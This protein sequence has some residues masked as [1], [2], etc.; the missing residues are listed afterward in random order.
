MKSTSGI[1]SQTLERLKFSYAYTMIKLKEKHNFQ[2]GMGIYRQRKQKQIGPI[3]YVICNIQI[4][5]VN[6]HL[7]Q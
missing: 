2:T 4:M 1:G 7:G 6:H 5:Q 3:G